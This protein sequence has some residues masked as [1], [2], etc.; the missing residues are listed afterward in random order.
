MSA[1]VERPPAP[2]EA[3]GIPVKWVLIAVGGFL[4]FAALS[5]TGLKLVYDRTFPPVATVPPKPMPQPGIQFDPTGDLRRLLAAQRDELAR[6]D[7]V[8]R[9]AGVVRIPV[10]R[11]MEIL[12]GRGTDVMLTGARL[13][14]PLHVG[15]AGARRAR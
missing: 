13:P 2:P 11:A 15:R 4:V 3:P 1:E 14:L 6:Y 12:A 10:S 9:G 8:D 7:W 5:M